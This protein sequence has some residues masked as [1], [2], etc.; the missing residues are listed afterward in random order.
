MSL[1]RSA[2]RVLIAEELLDSNM[3]ANKFINEA[4]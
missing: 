3:M 2:V 1:V 4:L